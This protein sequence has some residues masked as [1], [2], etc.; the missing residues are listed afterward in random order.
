MRYPE[1]LDFTL[2]QFMVAP[3]IAGQIQ[4]G[5]A[6]LLILPFRPQ[7]TVNR[8]ALEGLGLEAV[9]DDELLR[10]ARLA[11]SLELLLPPIAPIRIGHAFAL[12]NDI[13]SEKCPN[14]GTGIVSRMG[15]SRL[16]DLSSKHWRRCGYRTRVEFL[17]Y[18]D[19][20]AAD[21]HAGANPWCWLIE[22]KFKG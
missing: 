16:G 4:G 19:Q 10:A 8:A 22:F 14:F 15:I 9:S 2:Q 7:P 18:W 21:L 5:H 3:A 12:H 20:A 13:S 17:R 11:F 6:N 1:Q